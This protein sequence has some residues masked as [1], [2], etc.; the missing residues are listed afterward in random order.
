MQVDYSDQLTTDPNPL[1]LPPKITWDFSEATEPYFL[2]KSSTP[3]PCVTSA[4]E[5]FQN[6]L[7][8]ETGH[9]SCTYT[10]NK[11]SYTPQTGITY[12]HVVNSDAFTIDGIGIT[13][14]QAKLSGIP[15][16]P[17][18]TV[19]ILVAGVPT[20]V[21]YREV[22]FKLKFKAN[23]L[24]VVQDRGLCEIDPDHTGKLRQ[25]LKGT[26]PLPVDKPWPL[27]GSGAAK[28][29]ATDT[30]ATISLHPYATMAFASFG[31]S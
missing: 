7:Q 12:L 18:V 25:I 23:W 6:F 17:W 4:G 8:R 5:L 16:A 2:D 26:P 1:N 13:A 15:A 3:K 21:R 29:N 14:G 28:A 30:P 9:I 24:D 20:S 27:D 31:F 11:S 19:N 10:V 22:T